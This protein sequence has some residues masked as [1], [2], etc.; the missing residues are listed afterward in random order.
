MRE[1]ELRA[2]LDVCSGSIY[3]TQL[4]FE[5]KRRRLGKAVGLETVTVA[6]V[7]GILVCGSSAEEDDVV[8]LDGSGK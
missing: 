2:N 8:V 7:I 6:V 3:R 4:E 1:T 5:D